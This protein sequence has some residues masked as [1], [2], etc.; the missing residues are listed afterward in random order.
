MKSHIYGPDFSALYDTHWRDWGKRAW[1]LIEQVVVRRHPPPGPWLDLCCG[2]G[3]LLRIVT[4][5]GYEAVGVDTSAD[6]LR[7]ARRNAPQA[8]VVLADARR[9]HLRRRFDVVTCLFDSV[10]YFLND[11]DLRRFLKSALRHLAPGGQF[12][13]DV[14]TAAGFSARYR[15]TFAV[16][17]DDQVAT[18]VSSFHPRTL[19]GR[20]Q[21]VGF[22]R[23]G[24]HWRRY[25]EEHVQ[26]AFTPEF[27]AQELTTA[28]F[29]FRKM[30]G[31]RGGRVR[32][33]SGREMYICNAK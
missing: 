26:R 21:I 13:F 31:D 18:V 33:T 29:S 5:A 1:P 27:L 16:E 2:G 6:Q 19:L 23:S 24:R 9:L 10:N 11:A 14:N 4:R 3:S 7:Y 12:L 20:T 8:G 28:G 25:D 15:T 30:D 22:V 32:K 17:T